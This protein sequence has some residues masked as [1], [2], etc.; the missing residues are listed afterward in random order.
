MKPDEEAD[1]TAVEVSQHNL[2][3]AL[4]DRNPFKVPIDFCC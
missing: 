3:I 2:H 1:S 4:V